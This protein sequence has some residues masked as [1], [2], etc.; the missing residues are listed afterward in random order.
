[1]SS[2]PLK[3]SSGRI[4]RIALATQVQALQMVMRIA[5]SVRE[6]A[7]DCRPRTLIHVVWPVAQQFCGSK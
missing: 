5:L 3:T 2:M 7:L 6:D 1:M 4:S